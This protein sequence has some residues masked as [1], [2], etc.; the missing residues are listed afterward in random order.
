MEKKTLKLELTPEQRQRLKQET[1]KEVHA[2]KLNLEQLE[3]RMAP[4][5]TQN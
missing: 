5:I 3:T 1:G 2:V 4:R